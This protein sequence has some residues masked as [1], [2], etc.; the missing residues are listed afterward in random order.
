MENL[1]L[2]SIIAL[3]IAV[4]GMTGFYF[5]GRHTKDFRWSEYF[6]LLAGPIASVVFLAYSISWKI[7][8]LF[9]ASALL[10]FIFEFILG[11]FYEHIL[12][13]KLWTYGQW[14]LKGYTSY[15]TPPMWGVA[16]VIFYLASL[17]VGL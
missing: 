13:R 12:N 15:L 17:A 7:I 10:G 8:S 4:T 2:F 11:F 5:Y 3:T 1:Y 6:A 9:F 14:N 16:G